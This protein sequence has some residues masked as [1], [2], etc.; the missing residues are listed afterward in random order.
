MTLF[1]P[2]TGD[3]YKQA[4]AAVEGVTPGGEEGSGPAGTP[5]GGRYVVTTDQQRREWG[6]SDL[7]NGPGGD[8]AAPGDPDAMEIRGKCPALVSESQPAASDSAIAPSADISGMAHF[9]PFGPAAAASSRCARESSTP[10]TRPPRPDLLEVND[11]GRNMWTDD[12]LAIIIE[13]KREDWPGGPRT[14]TP[15]A[16]GREPN[17]RTLWY[18]AELNPDGRQVWFRITAEAVCRM[19][20][21]TPLAR[22]ERLIDA[23]LAWL[24]PDR[25]LKRELNRFE[26]Q[27]SDDGDTW[28]EL[29]GGEIGWV[30]LFFVDGPRG[31]CQR[32]G[33]S[34]LT[35]RRRGG[36]GGG[37]GL[38]TGRAIP[39]AYRWAWCPAGTPVSWKSQ[40][41]SRSRLA[42]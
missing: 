28:I 10:A 34:Y 2:V 7:A 24:T 5:A 38:L 6:L 13:G 35:R 33:K 12:G 37:G 23:L 18:G 15:R 17:G 41:A 36:E 19:R 4:R 20:E 3:E 30:R 40:Y 9:S 29:L 26:V 16:S 14:L 21:K 31:F 11:L 22:G 25:G 39:S 8:A 32:H 1:F 42:S 27:V